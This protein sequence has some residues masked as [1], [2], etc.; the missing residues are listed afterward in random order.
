MKLSDYKGT[1][2]LEVLA[3][4]IEPAMEIMADQA[5]VA[6]AREG[7][8]A[9]AVSA[10]IRNHKDAVLTVMAVLEREDPAEYAEKVNILTL[11][12]NLL[13]ILNDPEMQALFQSQGQKE[14]PKPSGSASE[15]TKARKK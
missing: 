4:L 15:N 12:K 3:D 8:M 5:V 13:A 9:R 14:A 1:E 2:A 11:P 10:A 6:A 7:K